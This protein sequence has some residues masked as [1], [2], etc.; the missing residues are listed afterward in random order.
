MTGMRRLTVFLA[1]LLAAGTASAITVERRPPTLAL[2]DL[3]PRYEM[4]VDAFGAMRESLRLALKSHGFDA[5]KTIDSYDD[6]ARFATGNAD[7]YLEIIGSERDAYAKGGGAAGVGPLDVGVTAVKNRHMLELR[8]YDGHTLEVLR[9]Y[10][11][12]ASHTSLVPSI[13]GVRGYNFFVSLFIAPWTERSQA[14]HAIDAVAREAARRIT[15][16]LTEHQRQP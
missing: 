8:V 14:Q 11:L 9:T 16:D 13:L 15:M 4:Q 10:Q 5:F 3:A 6:V 12:D 2:L 1:L 7:Y